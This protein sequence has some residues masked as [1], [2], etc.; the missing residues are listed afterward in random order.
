[1]AS[2]QFAPSNLVTDAGAYSITVE[3][4][5]DLLPSTVVTSAS[6]IY[7]YTYT[8][9]EVDLCLDTTLFWAHA[10]TNMTFISG[11]LDGF[12]NYLLSSQ[13][14]PVVSAVLCQ[15]NGIQ[16]CCGAVEFTISS[17]PAAG[18][19]ALNDS[20]LTITSTGGLVS[21]WTNNFNTVGQHIVTVTATLNAVVYSAVSFGLT[22]LSLDLS[23]LNSKASV[24]Y[25]IGFNNPAIDLRK[26]YKIS[27]A[28]LY[29]VSF[30]FNQTLGPIVSLAKI[31]NNYLDIG[32]VDFSFANQSV[33]FDI[34]AFT[35]LPDQLP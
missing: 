1:M 32:P 7:T 17:V 26:Y 28:N 11:Q 20:E 2:I 6:L 22:I 21:I 4:V 35:T 31:A 18:V 12:G 5:F 23:P 8:D 9:T 10:L 14:A 15:T 16:N 25:Q 29:L 19:A 13:Q 3:A 33:S 34:L 30:S 24:T 27:K